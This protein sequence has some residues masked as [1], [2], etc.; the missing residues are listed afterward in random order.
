MDNLIEKN[1]S[2]L[3]EHQFPEFFRTDGPTFVLFVK[4]YYEWLEG[5]SYEA[6]PIDKGTV[7][8][9]A[10]NENIT[11]LNTYF[12]TQ[13]QVGDYIALYYDD[14]DGFYEYFTVT[15]IISDTELKID[16]A[17]L[18]YSSNKSMFGTVKLVENVNYKAR[19]LKE[20]DD[21]D[22]TPEQYIV[23]FKEKYLKNLQ[24]SSKADTRN[25]IKHVLDLYRAKGTPRGIDLLFKLIFGSSAKVYYPGSDVFRLSNS[26]WFV[27]KYLEIS[28]K[29][30]TTKLVSKQITGLTSGATAFVDSVIRRTIK[31]RITDIAYISAINGEFIT[32]ELINTSDG[33]LDSSECPVI[34]GSLTSLDMD[35]RGSADGYAIGD[36]VDVYSANGEQAVARVAS[37]INITGVVDFELIEGGYA[38]KEDSQV[39]VS[40]KVFQVNNV[41]SNSRN[42]FEL[43]ETVSQPM[44]NLAFNNSTGE[45][46]NQTNIKTYFAN[47]SLAGNAQILTVTTINATHGSLL[48]S[49]LSGNLNVSYIGTSGN[50]ITANISGYADLTATANVI[51]SSKTIDLKVQ[52]ATDSDFRPL[53]IIYQPN[54]AT[55]TDQANAVIVLNTPDFGSNSFL[56]VSNT[57][58]VF[59]IA[60]PIYSRRSGANATVH[61]VT[62]KLGVK[63]IVN[64]FYSHPGNRISSNTTSGNLSIVGQGTGANVKISNTLLYTESANVSTTFIAPYGAV[65]LNA[66]AFGFVGNPTANA[67]NVISNA[68]AWQ[69]YTFGKVKALANIAIGQG[70]NFAPIVKIFEPL[71]YAYDVQDVFLQITGP[72][73]MYQVGEIIY[74]PSANSRGLVISANSTTVKA[75][76]LRVFPANG[77]IL[78]TNSSTQLIGESSAITSNIVSIFEDS[79]S[80]LNGTNALVETDTRTGN[81]SVTALEILSSGFGFVEGEEVNFRSATNESIGEATARL[82]KFGKSRGFFK[83]D[84][85]QLSGNKKLFD[86]LYYQDY[87]YEIRSSVTLDRYEEMLKKL[88]HMPGTKYFGALV[89]ESSNEFKPKI[90]TT[91]ITSS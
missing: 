21:V 16:A 32:G 8:F 28:L 74:Q 31:G 55:L 15:E 3:V 14:T 10:K 60:E 90:K 76:V 30:E 54:T 59:N 52:N 1:I 19:R 70:Y 77:F 72:T 27:P 47:N 75:Q 49:P 53:D 22:N 62:V 48:V 40:E 45:F 64:D 51:G 85:S 4:K 61:S 43:F 57:Y 7:S 56:K 71:T 2:N 13:F 83:N 91:I 29:E 46:S 33:L 41:T 44:A 20:Y 26:K 78:T 37:T 38:Y 39:L 36:I 67:G 63:D 34:V 88:M 66:T 18:T 23:Y 82:G 5:K 35:I 89:Y 80:A 87:S 50:T 12:L 17:N 81:G 6:V 86:G 11:G 58:G 42:Y 25:L 79:E 24:F 84:E 73:S 68:L 9:S 65:A 69:T